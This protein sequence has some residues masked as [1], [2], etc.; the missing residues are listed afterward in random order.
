M[1]ID[2]YFLLVFWSLF[3]YSF[4]TSNKI[5]FII[6]IIGIILIDIF[7]YPFKRR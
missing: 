1:T 3:C 4:Y 5:L 2:D 6:A 7:N